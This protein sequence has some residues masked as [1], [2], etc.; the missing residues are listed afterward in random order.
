VNGPCRSRPQRAPPAQHTRQAGFTY[1]GLMFAIAVIG[2][3]L[4]T[5][6][7]VWSTQIRRDKEAELLFVGDQYRT[8]IGR[9]RASGNQ[10]PLTLND[11]LEDKRY[12]QAR[13]YLRRLYPDPMTGSA[14]WQL[15]T[16]ADG[17]IMGVA[18]ASQLKPIKVAGFPALDAAFA[19]V[20]C[21]CGWRFIYTARYG[22]WR[23]NVSPSRRP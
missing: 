8:A 12:P 21:Y 22:G 2:I 14:D 16:A 10:F 23:R 13:R 20:D 4:A 18:S 7:V 9:Y 11:L 15:I 19:S 5:V 1:I 17:G 3:T 6:G